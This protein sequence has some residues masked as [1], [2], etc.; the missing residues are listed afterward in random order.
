V[1][2]ESLGRL[3]VILWKSGR[4]KRFL[5][6]GRREFKGEYVK[7]WGVGA[8]PFLREWGRERGL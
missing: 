2:V 3:P 7:K 1:G 6:G 8:R 5:H 4:T